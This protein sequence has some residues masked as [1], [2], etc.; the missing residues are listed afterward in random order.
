LSNDLSRVHL[1][2]VHGITNEDVQNQP[3][4]KAI[5][6]GVMEMI[7]NSDLAGFNLKSFD[8]PLLQAELKRA[9]H[10]FPCEDRRVVDVKEIYHLYEQRTLSDAV[11]FYCGTTHD[12]AHSS[13]EDALATWRVLEA[14]VAKYGLPIPCPTLQNPWT[15]HALEDS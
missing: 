8:L 7:R 13:L 15:K 9:G 14:Q 4:L 1:Q 6:E 3:T 10:D 5:A 2:R 11:K 12:G